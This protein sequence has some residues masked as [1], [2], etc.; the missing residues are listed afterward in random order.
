MSSQV[1]LITTSFSKMAS[2][3]TRF[4]EYLAA[5]MP[6]AVTAI[7]DLAGIVESEGVGVVVRDE[8]DDSLRRAARHLVDMGA[9][10]VVRARCREVARV[11]FDIDGGV[12][13]YAELYRIQAG[14]GG[15][16]GRRPI[17]RGAGA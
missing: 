1:F 13:Q 6:V 15:G 7:G 12:A 11:H 10:P 5:G 3:P 9:D 4:A 14:L 2:A 16:A 8:D 17:V